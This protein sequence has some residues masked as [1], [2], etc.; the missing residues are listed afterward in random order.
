MVVKESVSINAEREMALTRPH[1]AI[2]NLGQEL[3]SQRQETIVHRTLYELGLLLFQ[4]EMDLVP[5]RLD[6]DVWRPPPATGERGVTHNGHTHV[7]TDIQTK[8]YTCT[9]RYIHTYIHTAYHWEG[10][11]GGSGVYTSTLT[12]P[13]HSAVI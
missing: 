9:Q 6:W 10:G 7:D 12:P 11:G 5:D 8:T 4:E 3:A 2:H 13:C 1:G